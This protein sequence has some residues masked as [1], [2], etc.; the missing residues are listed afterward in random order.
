MLRSHTDLPHD[1]VQTTHP[2]LSSYLQDTKHT[3]DIRIT[4]QKQEEQASTVGTPTDSTTVAPCCI[5]QGLDKLGLPDVGSAWHLPSP[6]RSNYP[7][8]RNRSLLKAKLPPLR[9][10]QSK[11]LLKDMNTRR[12]EKRYEVIDSGFP[13][14]ACKSRFSQTLR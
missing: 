13:G 5:Q 12:L 2:P 7:F 9:E 1:F 3:V 8:E 10:A 14:Y 4:I 6:G 11:S